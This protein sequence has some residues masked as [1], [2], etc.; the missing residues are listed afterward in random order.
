MF[1]SMSSWYIVSATSQLLNM[2]ISAIISLVDASSV[3]EDSLIRIV[4]GL[5]EAFRQW[6]R[7]FAS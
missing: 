4:E 7:K 6:V 5:R 3:G 2:N 1:I